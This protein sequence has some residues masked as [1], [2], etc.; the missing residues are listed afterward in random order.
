VDDARGCGDRCDVTLDRRRLGEADAVVFHIPTTGRLPR[1]KRRGQLWVA[2][3]A[4]SDVNYPRL[5]DRGFMRRFDLTATYRTTSDVV[6][7]YATSEHLT[8]LRTPPRPKTAP[9]P[10]VCMASSGVDRSGRT[11]YVRELMRYMAVDSYGS[12]LRNRHLPR[13]GGRATKLET[14]GRYPFTLAFENSVARDYVTEK[15]YDALV[16]GSVPVYLGAPNVRDLAPARHCH[17]DVTDFAGRA[18]AEHLRDL[19]ADPVRYAEYLAWKGRPLDPAFVA[20][21]EEQRTPALCRL[22]DVVAARA[23]RLDGRGVRGAA[24]A[25]RRP[26]R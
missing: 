25:P 24:A 12:S 11:A 23:R 8:S 19:L 7:A 13:D 10:A 16:A 9:A 22:C 3:S 4:E 17:L 20:R 2:W 26:V 6:L 14:I 1:R 21:A 5:A 15:Y 18:L